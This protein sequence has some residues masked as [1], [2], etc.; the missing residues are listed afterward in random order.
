MPATATPRQIIS[1][2]VEPHIADAVRELAR[3]DHR[4]VSNY[5]SVLIGQAV[6]NDN[7][8][9]TGTGVN[10]SGVGRPRRDQP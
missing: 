8:P 5:L 7:G 6:E 3:C 9:V 2:A 4:T 10:G 1:A